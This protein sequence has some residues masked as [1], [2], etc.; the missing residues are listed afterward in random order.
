MALENSTLKDINGKQPRHV[1]CRRGNVLTVD[2]LLEAYP[3]GIKVRDNYGF[4]PIHAACSNGVSLRQVLEAYPEGVKAENQ[5]GE[6]PL[7]I[8]LYCSEDHA[9]PIQALK[10]LTNAYP[11]SVR[12]IGSDGE[13]PLHMVINFP[14]P[15]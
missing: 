7:Y 2:T 5:N 4:L 15:R 3:K 6:L 10:L 1:A 14:D 12:K 11:N 8:M 13:L 9:N